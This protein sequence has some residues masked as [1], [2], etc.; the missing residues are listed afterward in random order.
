MLLLNILYVQNFCKLHQKIVFF[1]V[2]EVSSFIQA[3]FNTK[4][5]LFNFQPKVFVIMLFLI[6][7]LLNEIK[8]FDYLNIIFVVFSCLFSTLIVFNSINEKFIAAWFASLWLQT[9][10]IFFNPLFSSS[11]I[12]RLEISTTKNLVA[13]K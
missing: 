7:F 4:T 12:I 8:Y 6:F 3:Y 13:A 2:N 1:G 10:V 11:L 5:S 9:V